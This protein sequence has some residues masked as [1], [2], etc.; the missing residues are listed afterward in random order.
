M[1]KANVS[2]IA[3]FP[4]LVGYLVAVVFVLRSYGLTQYS[5]AV[6]AV[7]QSVMLLIQLYS[8]V[9]LD[10]KWRASIVRKVDPSTFRRHIWLQGMFNIL[11]WIISIVAITNNWH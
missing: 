2:Y 3:W 4:V 9:A 5:F 7:I 6:I 1:L 8:G 10:S 11:C